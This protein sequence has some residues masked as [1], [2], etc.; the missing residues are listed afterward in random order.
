VYNDDFSQGTARLLFVVNPTL[1]DVTIP[2]GEEL[3]GLNP[4][5]WDMLADHE[6]FYV[7]DSHRASKPVEPALLAPALSCGLWVSEREG[8]G[9]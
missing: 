7:S 2:L 9:R 3:V 5:D 6:R 1:A 4:A 8:S